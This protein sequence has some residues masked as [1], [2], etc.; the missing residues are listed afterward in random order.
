MV[1]VRKRKCEAL[2]NWFCERINRF[3]CHMHRMETFSPFRYN[4][5]QNIVFDRSTNVYMKYWKCWNLSVKP[6]LVEVQKVGH[7]HSQFVP[8]VFKRSLSLFH[9]FILFLIHFHVFGA[10]ASP[11][12]RLYITLKFNCL[13]AISLLILCYCILFHW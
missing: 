1:Y 9:S 12:I 6:K 10:Y 11:W 5:L 2:I 13:K 3:L 4:I 8:F 7:C